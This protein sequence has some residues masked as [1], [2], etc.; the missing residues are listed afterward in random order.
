MRTNMTATALLTF[1]YPIPPLDPAKPLRDGLSVAVQIGPTLWVANDETISLERL[2]FQDR[3][4]QGTYHYGAHQSFP[5]SDYLA[6]PVPLTPDTPDKKV[7]EIDVEG[8]AYQDGYLW[9]VGS[10]SRKRKKVNSGTSVRKNFK[11][12]ANVKSEGNRYLLA[13]IPLVTEDGGLPTLAKRVRAED[14]PVRTAAQLPTDAEGNLLTRML[15]EDEH[16]KDFLDIPG[17]DNGFDIEGLAV[18]GSRLFLGLRGPVLR[19]WAIVLEIEV[20]ATEPGRL[21]LKVINSDDP[22]RPTYRKHFLQLGGLGVREL[23]VQGA[24]LLIL[25]GPTMDLD[26]PVTLY[27]WPGGAQP[28]D[29]SLVFSEQLVALG[30]IPFGRGD[31]HAEGMTLFR[32]AEQETTA[33]LVVYDASAAG[34]KVGETG[35]KADIFSLS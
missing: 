20:A 15:R 1:E 28:P 2:T 6:L 21:E 33:I 34:R 3:D 17:K 30:A 13:R 7:E 19:G 4:E 5:L 24:D 35:V 10:H 8:L 16:L 22:Q 26:G 12:L 32:N 9:V 11:R 29:E 31:D 25:A 23:C 14:G 18:V 27:R